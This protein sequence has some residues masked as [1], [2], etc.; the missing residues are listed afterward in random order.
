MNV[1]LLHTDNKGQVQRK[2]R[3]LSDAS[4]RRQDFRPGPDIKANPAIVD[5]LDNAFDEHALP[6]TSN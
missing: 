2:D 3:Q 1:Q 6:L 5:A 4:W